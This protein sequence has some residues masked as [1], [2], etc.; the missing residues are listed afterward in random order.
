MVV[1]S[2]SC[3]VAEISGAH[4]SVM[5][6]SVLGFAILIAG[7]VVVLA[8][9]GARRSAARAPSHFNGDG[10]W[11]A[12]TSDGSTGDCGAGDAGGCDGGGGG[13]GE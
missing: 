6:I 3:N 9:L 5:A 2:L 13:G 8:L 4:T 11:M 10:A 7:L 1:G 12:F